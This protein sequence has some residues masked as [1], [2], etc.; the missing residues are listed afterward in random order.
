MS[1]Y[2][3]FYSNPD[4]I[5]LSHRVADFCHAPFPTC[6]PV[7]KGAKRYNLAE[8][9]E[10]LKENQVCQ[11]G[12]TKMGKLHAGI[13]VDGKRIHRELPEG[14]TSGDAKLVE[15]ELRASGA[16]PMTAVLA[17]F[18]KHAQALR[19]AETAKHQ[20]KRLGP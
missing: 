13:M 2:N 20:A 7:G 8:C 1:I 15:M 19:S 4:P 11:S 16:L 9:K 18:V 6:K 10:W 17:L 12:K 5:V 14:A 3:F